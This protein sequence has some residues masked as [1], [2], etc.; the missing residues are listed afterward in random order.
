[1]SGDKR[2]G[3]WGFS[4]SGMLRERVSIFLQ[5]AERLGLSFGLKTL[6]IEM[7]LGKIY[8]LL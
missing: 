5:F 2:A 7:F 8:R 3:C 4:G 6:L 1:M